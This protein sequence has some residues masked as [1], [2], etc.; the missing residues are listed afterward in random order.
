MK[1]WQI[2]QSQVTITE[3][4]LKESTSRL[5]RSVRLSELKKKIAPLKTDRLKH[6]EVIHR[7]KFEEVISDDPEKARTAREKAEAD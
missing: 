2:H 7:L 3:V 5:V 1:T 6:H 4:G